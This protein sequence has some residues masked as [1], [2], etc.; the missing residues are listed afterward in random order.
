MTSADLG[1][2]VPRTYITDVGTSIF[3]NAAN[4]VRL[5][6]GVTGQSQGT[7]TSDNQTAVS[8]N[9]GGGVQGGN[10]WVLDGVPD[11]VPL[12]TGSVV[13][14]PAVDAIEEMKVHTTM[15]DAA[16]GHSTGGAV[17]IVTKSGTNALRG[18]ALRVPAADRAGGELVG[19][20][21][22]PPARNRRSTTGSAAAA[23]A[24]RWCCRTPTTGT[25]ARSG[26]PPTKATATCATCFRAR[27]CR[28]RPKR[29][30]TSP[31]RSACRARR[32][33][34]TTRSARC[35]RPPARS[36]RARR[37]CATATCR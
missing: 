15:F 2:V 28:R 36:S 3:R 6:P 32:S 20:Q 4:F 35:C 37:S 7:Y 31:L 27:A 16:Y 17:T 22:Q 13:V 26:S 29:R 14:V 5:A 11:T 12:S 24:V 21:P 9:G 25:T 33:C 18:D 1:Q 19:Q 23:P 34:S 8:I 10:E 30:A